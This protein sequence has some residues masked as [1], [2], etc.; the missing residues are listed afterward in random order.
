M[1]V[2]EKAKF[3]ISR[4]RVVRHDVFHALVKVFIFVWCF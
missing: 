3:C 2:A 4:L 1:L